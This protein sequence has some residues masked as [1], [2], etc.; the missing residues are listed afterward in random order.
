MKASEIEIGGRYR[1]RI[2]GKIV[3]VEVLDKHEEWYGSLLARKSRTAYRVKN[4]STGRVVVFHS[5]QKFRSRAQP[6]LDKPTAN[7]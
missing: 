4:L 7:G 3:I 1:A 5:A 2:S 6:V